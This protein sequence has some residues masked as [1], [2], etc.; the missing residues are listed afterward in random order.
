M[1]FEF[2]LADQIEIFEDSGAREVFLLFTNLSYMKLRK[3]S[4]ALSLSKAKATIKTAQETISYKKYH[5]R[6]QLVTLKM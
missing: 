2:E 6:K 3:I 1:F 5:H 4:V